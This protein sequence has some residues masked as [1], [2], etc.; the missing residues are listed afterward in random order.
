MLRSCNKD[1]GETKWESKLV[2]GSSAEIPQTEMPATA[3]WPR[4]P[5]G[6]ETPLYLARLGMLTAPQCCVVLAGS[7]DTWQHLA[8][9][10]RHQ[11][12]PGSLQ[13]FSRRHL[14]LCPCG[15]SSTGC[16]VGQCGA[17]TKGCGDTFAHASKS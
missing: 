13:G 8:L 5:L 1:L 17:V 15:V 3:G 4:T 10:P 12:V 7:T 14:L 16:S 9:S 11:T 6:T 2:R